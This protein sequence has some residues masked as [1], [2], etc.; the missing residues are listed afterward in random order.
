[1]PVVRIC[2]VAV[3]ESDRIGHAIRHGV[4]IPCGR[5]VRRA[6]KRRRRRNFH[7][8]LR[9]GGASDRCYNGRQSDQSKMGCHLG[10]CKC[11]GVVVTNVSNVVAN[12]WSFLNPK[13]VLLHGADV[14]QTAYFSLSG[15]FPP[16]A[17]SS[18]HPSSS[19][20]HWLP[21]VPT[22]PPRVVMIRSRT[23]VV[24]VGIKPALV[25]ASNVALG[26]PSPQATIAVRTR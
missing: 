17:A 5:R 14:A 18:L 8:R 21:P 20:S 2:F 16:C 4:S 25:D 24:S 11:G 23:R 13:A 6:L 10:L 9:R 26:R 12:T 3:I 19:S 15:A 22:C 1:M 7:A